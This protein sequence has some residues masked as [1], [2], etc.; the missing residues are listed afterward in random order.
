VTALDE[1]ND[2]AAIK[3]SKLASHWARFNQNALT[4]AGDNAVAFGFPLSGD[5]SSLGNVTAGNVSA[6]SGLKDDPRYYQITAP[7]QP[8]NS[9]G[10]L[11]DEKGNVIGIITA[12]LDAL[13]V[14]RSTGDIPQNINFS[15]KATLAKA[16]MSINSITFETSA[17]RSALS[18]ADIGD[19]GRS[20]SVK[21][22]CYK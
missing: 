21:L 3:I 22:D 15:L 17:A 12:K 18:T 8:G 9:G 7:V 10:P 4:R 16:F 5:L 11:L 20:I 2:I 6:L 14:A 19:I 1:H 13:E